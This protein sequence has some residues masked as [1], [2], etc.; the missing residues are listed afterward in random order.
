MGSLIWTLACLRSR[1]GRLVEVAGVDELDKFR[2]RRGEA[3]GEG[4]ASSKVLNIRKEQLASQPFGEL[5]PLL[6]SRW[7]AGGL[8]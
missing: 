6:A 7:S 5:A 3:R 4:E 2:P 8:G 1:R